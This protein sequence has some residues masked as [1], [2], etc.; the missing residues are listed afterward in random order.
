MLPLCFECL[1][2]IFLG[3]K[4][5][6]G[7]KLDVFL[8]LFWVLLALGLA[9]FSPGLVLFPA[10]LGTTP[11]FLGAS[12]FFICCCGVLELVVPLFAAIGDWL[13]ALFWDV[14]DC[15]D[16]GVGE[17]VP[18][19]VCSLRPLVI[20]EFGVSLCLLAFRF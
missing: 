17:G 18:V 9:G 1:E 14:D 16:V 20:L 15:W 11:L 8:L 7:F 5:R 3:L 13:P 4:R 12:G 2:A 6:D 10:W 19:F